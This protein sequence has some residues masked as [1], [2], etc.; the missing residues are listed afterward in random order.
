MSSNGSQAP[1]H[2][3]GP[4]QVCECRYASPTAVFACISKRSVADFGGNN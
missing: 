1:A 4:M 3:I 2:V